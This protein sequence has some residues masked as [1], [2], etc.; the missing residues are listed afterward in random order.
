MEL[1]I[2]VRLRYRRKK[3]KA[4]CADTG[5]ECTRS[6]VLSAVPNV[7]RNRNQWESSTIV[8]EHR[9]DVDFQPAQHSPLQQIKMEKII[10]LI[11]FLW[12]PKQGKQIN[13]KIISEITFRVRRF[14]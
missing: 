14:S 6:R 7:I 10:I 1:V 5:N 8:V 2:G 9:R 4:E 3:K 12:K 11:K 13:V